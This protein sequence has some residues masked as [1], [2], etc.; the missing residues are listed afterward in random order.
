MIVRG[1]GGREVL[2]K[3][4]YVKWGEGMDRVLKGSVDG[5]RYLGGVGCRSVCVGG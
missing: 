3:I 4:G 5:E 1:I 2:V